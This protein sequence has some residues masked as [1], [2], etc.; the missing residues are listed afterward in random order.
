MSSRR[1]RNNKKKGTLLKFGF[2]LYLGLCLFTIVW[3]RTAVFNLEYEL[4]E[5][6][7]QRAEL[8]SERKMVA[9]QRASFFSVGN[10]ENVA[11]NRLGMSRAER[12]NIFFVKSTRAAGA[13]R[14][15]TR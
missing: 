7:N 2:F 13:Y 12:E 3:L 9:A 10:V 1:T 15:S 8:I 14:A 4:G 5:L 11:I 6:E